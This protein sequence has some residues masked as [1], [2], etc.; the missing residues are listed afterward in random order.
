MSEQ[1]IALLVAG[2]QSERMQSELPKPYLPLG[3][4]PVLRRALRAFLGHDGIQGVRVVIRREHHA[5]YKKA[6][7]G[8]T[9]FPCV[10]GGK[11]RQ[12]SVRLGLESIAHR[13]PEFVL[14]HDVARPLASPK[15][16]WRV[17]RALKDHPAVIPARKL[18]DTVKRIDGGHIAETIHRENL[19]TAQ[20]PQGFRFEALLEAH[21]RFAGEALTDD[22]AVVE[23]AGGTVTIVEGDPENVKITTL[24]DLKRMQTLL[25]ITNETRTGIGYDVHPLK[26]HD[27]DTPLSRQTIKLCGVRIPFTH[28]L[29]GHSDADVGLH[30]LVDALLGAIGAGDIGIHFPPDDRKWQGA[31]SERFLMHAYELLKGKGG[32]LVHLDVTLIC[33]RPHIAEWRSRMIAHIAQ[34]LKLPEGRISIKATTTEKLGFTGRGEGIAAQ[35]VATV[36]LP[37]E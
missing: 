13:Q 28:R 17:L 12:E 23:K 19:Y 3:G 11:S 10:I 35:A 20:T 27:A 18:I 22:A 6:V 4:E 15:L 26:A 7:E 8:L 14:V 9:L 24:E 32:E 29:I 1:T 5:L 25:T 36:R 21:R 16:I 34:I 2:G 33:E 30:A 31:D 37:R